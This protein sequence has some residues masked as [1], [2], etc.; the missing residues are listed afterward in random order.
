MKPT[1][2][3]PHTGVWPAMLTP[4]RADLSIDT[5]RLAAHAQR[6]IAAGCPGVTLFGTT[7]EGPSFA[8]AERQQALEAL[9]AHG[10]P[11]QRVLVHT[12][13]SALPETVALTR[14]AT[15]LGVHGCLVLP[16]FFFKG[17]SDV[18]V[19]DAYRHVFDACRDLPLRVV[20]YHIPQVAGVAVN[21]EVIAELLRLYPD[22]IIGLKDSG[23]QRQGSLAY[24]RALMP[25]IQ[26]WVGNETDIPE[27]AQQGTAGA[28]SG[29]ANMF[30]GLVGRLVTGREPAAVQADLA[31]VQGFLGLIGGYTMIPAF[32]GVMAVI[33]NDLS[34]LPVRA[35]LLALSPDEWHRLRAQ[36]LAFQP[37][38]AL[39]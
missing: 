10:V 31:R 34:W 2:H 37:G 26:V 20:L 24:A 17:V 9:L 18:G 5:E 22:R 29:V 19:L 7:G 23:C 14:H 28:V 35:P 38:G 32:K 4:L 36:W 15:A 21:A 8:V 27:M 39:G 16:P 3:L 12:S 1:A 6:L 11:A 30:P 33:D 25:P 13:C